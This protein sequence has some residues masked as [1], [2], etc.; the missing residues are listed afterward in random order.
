MELVT[1]ATPARPVRPAKRVCVPQEKPHRVMMAT[2]VRMTVVIRLRVARRPP[3]SCPVM[4]GIPAPWGI[5]VRRAHVRLAR[6]SSYVRTI[7]PALT[8]AVTRPQGVC[9]LPTP[10]HVTIRMIAPLTTSVQMVPVWGRV[11]WSVMMATR[12]RWIVAYPRVAAR[13]MPSKEAVTMVTRVQ[14]MIRAWMVPVPAV[15]H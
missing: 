15:G 1:T 5:A 9:S 12:V 4:M 8:I 6:G 3:T 14:S 2:R 10:T 11:R 7:I 13:M